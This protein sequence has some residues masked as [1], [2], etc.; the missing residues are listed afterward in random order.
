M[1]E[2]ERERER[3]YKT[4]TEVSEHLTDHRSA[5]VRIAITAIVLLCA[6]VWTVALRT[7]LAHLLALCVIV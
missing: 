5:A 1:L 2:R 7:K 3:E 6:Y 4:H